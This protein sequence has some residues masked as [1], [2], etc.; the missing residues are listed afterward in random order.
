M[1]RR[2]SKP[3]VEVGEN[4]SP[5][6]V[7]PNDPPV[8][9]PPGSEVE[10][11]EQLEQRYREEKEIRVE[12][13][14]RK[15]KAETQQADMLASTAVPAIGLLLD[16]VAK[17]MPNPIPVEDSEKELIGK[18]VESVTRKYAPTLAGYSEEAA[19][20]FALAVFFVPRFITE[21][22]GKETGSRADTGEDGKRKDNASA[23]G[24]K[25]VE[26]RDLSRSNVGV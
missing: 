15:P 3:P 8:I 11:P 12:R 25:A 7:P 21:G 24:D 13:R 20:L 14:G 18:A 22:D 1:R 26:S 10:T 16:F 19:L 6:D 2:N 9:P 4:P 23:T 5:A 17:R